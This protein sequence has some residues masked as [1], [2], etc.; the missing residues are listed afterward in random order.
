MLFF[1]YVVRVEYVIPYAF[2]PRLALSF[3]AAVA[4]VA[5]ETGLARK[6]VDPEEVKA[7]TAKRVAR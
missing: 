1:V 4:K 6:I 3:V 2:D 7:N 5:I